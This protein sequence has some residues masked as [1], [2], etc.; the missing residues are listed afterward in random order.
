[1]VENIENGNIEAWVWN[2]I[3]QKMYEEEDQVLLRAM[4]IK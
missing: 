1:M 2:R 4:F 3:V